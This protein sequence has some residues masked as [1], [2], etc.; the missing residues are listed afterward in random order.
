ME[1][2]DPSDESVREEL[3]LAREELSRLADVERDLALWKLRARTAEGLA[4]QWQ[5]TQQRS[6]WRIFVALERTRTRVA[7][8]GTRRDR[9]AR[10]TARGV[11]RALMAV[12]PGRPSTVAHREPVGR[13]AALLVY[14]DQGAHTRYRC[15]H[16]SEELAYLGASSDITQSEQID[17]A[18]AVDHYELF[19]LNRVK[20]NDGVAALLERARARN[21][22]V[23]FDT[24][25]LVF[26]PRLERHFAF[27]DEWGERERRS[28]I[29]ALA[30]F[31]TTLRA[32]GRSTVSTE[33][34]REHA[35]R[36][37]ERSE[38]LPNAVSVDMLQLA[39]AAL[40]GDDRR[41]R[42]PERH[43][44]R[45]G[46]LSGSRTHRRDFKE[47]ADAVLWALETY[48]QVELLVVGKLDLDEAF[49]SF[50][51]RIAEI[52]MQPWQALP[53]L[54]SR[55][56]VNLAPLE[57]DNPVADCKSCVKYLE[58]GLLGVPTIASARADFLRVI[59]HGRNGLLADSPEEWR[60]ALR[61]LIESSELR[62][63]LG[64][65]A[66]DDVRLHHT[67]KARARLVEE[68]LTSLAAGER[69]GPRNLVVNWLVH[70]ANA[71]DVDLADNLAE[72]GH[73]V[74]VCVETGQLAPADVTVATDAITAG[75]AARYEHS[76]FK[77]LLVSTVD[78]DAAAYDLPLRV[79]CRGR[80]AAERLGALTGRPIDSIDESGADA[81]DQLE[82]ILLRTCFADATE[83]P[84]LER[85]A[86]ITA[87]P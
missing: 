61:R 54:L 45:I 69:G 2:H 29:D 76:P 43:T 3:R 15:E 6:I 80:D 24:D 10:A 26:E 33:P 34:L 38:L 82:R 71:S 8:P 12:S 59:H 85:A 50:E 55:T 35:G 36:Y 25:D 84:S 53:E 19:V 5:Q 11:A 9:A 77:C 21:R 75:I 51:S 70:G 68:L 56:D 13:K 14:D 23:I 47:A 72:R 81:G 28:W 39:D 7:P 62:R 27:L 86:R 18:A 60:D 42:L 22:T 52:P 65:R 37:C 40:A 64:S 66:Y 1:P 48:P 32:C 31:Q 49:R 63:E 78:E 74:R 73:G 4:A 79:V 58:A 41:A 16:L 57:R 87:S 17:L 30:R 20:W 46:Y 83:T 44:V 67:T